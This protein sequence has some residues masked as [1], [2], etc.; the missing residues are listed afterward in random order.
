VHAVGDTAYSS[1][2]AEPSG[3]SNRVPQCE[4]NGSCASADSALV[5]STGITSPPNRIWKRGERRLSITGASGKNVLVA[6]DDIAEIKEHR[7][8]DCPVY[9]HHLMYGTVPPCR[10]C[11]E[12]LMSQVRSHLNRAAG[13][14]GGFPRFVQQCRRCKQDFVER[15]TYDSHKSANTCAHQRQVRR[16]IVI[17]WARQYL[18]IYPEARQI[19]LPWC[20]E[21]GWLPVS[22]LNHC[23]GSCVNSIAHESFLERGQ[24]QADS[25]LQTQDPA[26]NSSTDPFYNNIVGFVMYDLVNPTFT[27]ATGSSTPVQNH[28]RQDTVSLQEMTTEVSSRNDNYW[29]RVLRG[30]IHQQRTMLD[31]AAHLTEVQLRM[32]AEQCEQMYALSRTFYQQRQPQLTHVQVHPPITDDSFQIENLDSPSDLPLQ[33][34]YATPMRPQYDQYTIPDPNTQFVTLNPSTLPSTRSYGTWSSRHQAITDPSSTYNTS[35]LSPCSTSPHRRSSLPTGIEQDALRFRALPSRISLP[36]A[37]DDCIDPSLLDS[38]SE[39]NDED[40][41]GILQDFS[42]RRS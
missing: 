7:E 19:P 15:Q 18:A 20:D 10:G 35:L 26:E 12:R 22:V 27:Q 25:H 24:G 14:H 34:H 36:T 31:A 33:P 41:Y 29:N 6:T 40:Y 11:R 3:Y 1:R 16:D 38:P 13:S 8:V 5:H 30:F 42:A 28:A 39:D 9:K 2:A 37:P 23:R 4:Q 17:S 32:Q 21:M